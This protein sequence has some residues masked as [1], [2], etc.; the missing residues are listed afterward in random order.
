MEGFETIVYLAKIAT[1]LYKLQTTVY[2][3]DHCSLGQAMELRNSIN[4]CNQVTCNMYYD[5]D[6]KSAVFEL[7]NER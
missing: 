3:V 1:E 5:Y 2:K 6:N 7:L 4:S